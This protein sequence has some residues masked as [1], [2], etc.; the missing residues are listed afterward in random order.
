MALQQQVPSGG[1]AGAENSGKVILE[2]RPESRSAQTAH[3]PLSEVSHAQNA[4]DR[5]RDMKK[6]RRS[7]VDIY[8]PMPDGS[9]LRLTCKIDPK[10]KKIEAGS[11]YALHPGDYVVVS[12]D[13]STMWDDMLRNVS[14]P[15]K[16]LKR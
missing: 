6:F 2:V 10:S 16:M 5:S 9:S 3:V 12:E 14:G 7:L 1:T 13:P 15:M 8:R 11:D 4:L